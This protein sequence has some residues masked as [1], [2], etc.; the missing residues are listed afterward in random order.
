[1]VLEYEAGERYELWN[2]TSCGTVRNGLAGE[3]Y[4]LRNGTGIREIGRVWQMNIL[5]GVS[6]RELLDAIPLTHYSYKAIKEQCHSLDPLFMKS[7]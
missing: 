3:R 5:S 4:E 2:G 7:H 6:M 1:M